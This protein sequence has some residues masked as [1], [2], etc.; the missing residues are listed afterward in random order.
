M[1][2]LVFSGLYESVFV[3]RVVVCRAFGFFIYLLCVNFE[4]IVVVFFIVVEDV[5]KLVKILVMWLLVN[6]CVVNVMRENWLCD[7]IVVSLVKVLIAS[8]VE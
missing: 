8:A 5:L 1:F 7:D 6:F 4:E 3:V 2:Y